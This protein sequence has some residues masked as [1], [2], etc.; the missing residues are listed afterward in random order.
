MGKKRDMDGK[1]LLLLPLSRLLNLF[2]LELQKETKSF[3]ALSE[4]VRKTIT[5]SSLWA[6]YEIDSFTYMQMDLTAGFVKKNYG[7]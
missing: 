6:K 3:D 1:L 7:T 4:S 5:K 2:L